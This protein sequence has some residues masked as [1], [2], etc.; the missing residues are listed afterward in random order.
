MFKINC[1]NLLGMNFIIII[2]II[3]IIIN[4]KFSLYLKNSIFVNKIF[5][6]N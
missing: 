4:D 2:I 3:I 6:T 5:S 1:L